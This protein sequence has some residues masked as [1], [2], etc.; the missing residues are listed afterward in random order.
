M[1]LRILLE[2]M[3]QADFTMVGQQGK[4]HSAGLASVWG[5]REAPCLGFGV[6]S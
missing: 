2:E 4:G 1:P 3:E 6:T 5:S